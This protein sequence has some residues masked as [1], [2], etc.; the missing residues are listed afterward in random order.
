[1]EKI[2]ESFLPKRKKTFIITIVISL[3]LIL[4]GIISG[5]IGIVGNA[6]ILSIF[7]I[8]IPQAILTYFEYRDI[9]EMEIKFPVF[10]RDLT[11]ATRSGL[12]LHKAIIHVSRIDYGALSKEVKKMANQLSWGVNII[13]VLEQFERRM[14]ASEMLSKNV[15]IIIETYKSGGSIDTTLDSLASTLM[16]L[17]ETNNER[18]SSLNQYVVAMYAITYIFIGIIIGIDKLMIP[19]FTS[20][21]VGSTGPIG[22]IVV[23][24]CD[25]CLYVRNPSCIPCYVYFNICSFFHTD[26]T[27]MGCYYLAL[28][29]SMTVVQSICGGLVAGQISEGSVKA[30]LK[31][32]LILLLSSFGIF[33]ILVRI[34]LLGG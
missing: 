13:K 12:P 8:A 18:K 24:P 21:S 33:F 30:G 14:K 32:S 31:H 10:L 23:N 5:D 27:T 15:R 17:Q 34:G 4:L 1:M 20:T 25:Q 11:E 29:F 16:T 2:L 26:R 19:I 22:T 7:L 9:K 3:L 28:F 6:I